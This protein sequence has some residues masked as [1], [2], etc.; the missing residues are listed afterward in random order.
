MPVHHRYSLHLL[1]F[2]NSPE[3]PYKKQILYT[4][5]MCIWCVYIYFLLDLKKKWLIRST[6][7]TSA[8]NYFF[9]SA[10]VIEKGSFFLRVLLISSST[11]CRG[12]ADRVAVGLECVLRLGDAVPLTLPSS[13]PVSILDLPCLFSDIV[14]ICLRNLS[15]FS[16]F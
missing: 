13:P 4:Y 11:P 1:R 7:E 6:F 9:W 12:H 16:E 2:I 8:S 3:R 14:L 5:I 10:L 15:I